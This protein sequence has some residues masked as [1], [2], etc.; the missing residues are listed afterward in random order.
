M[1][2]HPQNLRTR[3]VILGRHSLVEQQFVE[4]IFQNTYRDTQRQIHVSF[5]TSTAAAS[6]VGPLNQQ[7]FTRS[8]NKLFLSHGM[9]RRSNP[10][11]TK[12]HLGSS[13]DAQQ[14]FLISVY[15]F[16]IHTTSFVEHINYHFIMRRS[17]NNNNNKMQ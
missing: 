3:I 15:L 7:F 17:I 6:W 4:N 16:L 12:Y 2:S 14:N 5:I 13:R 8:Q 10:F 1:S 9:Q 11:D